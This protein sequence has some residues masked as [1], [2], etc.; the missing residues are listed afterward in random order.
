MDGV[1]STANRPERMVLGFKRSLSLLSRAAGSP[2]RG[3]DASW[4]FPR[5]RLT[6][7]V[8][9]S[10]LIALLLSTSAGPAWADPFDESPPEWERLLWGGEIL[11]RDKPDPSTTLTGSDNSRTGS[12]TLSPARNQESQASASHEDAVMRAKNRATAWEKLCGP[13]AP[14][15]V[16]LS[17]SAML[18]VSLSGLPLD[19]CRSRYREITLTKIPPLYLSPPLPGEGVWHSQDMPTGPDGNPV[20]YRTSYRPSVEYP[21][22]IV[23]MLLF[24]MSRL[25]MRL[26]LGSSEPG[27]S[28]ETSMIP[29]ELRPSL[30]AITNALWK[31]KH[32]G[33]AG[34]IFQGRVV[35]ELAPGMAT[36]VVYK[37]DSVD[38][39]EWTE[40]I[41]PSLV[42]DARQLRH[43][44]VKNS[45]VVESIVRAGQLADAEIGL[46]F[47][48]SEDPGET[49]PTYWYGLTPWQSR[50]N[51]GPDWFIASRSAFGIRPDG[52]LVFA[53]GHHIS[54]RDLAKAMVLAGCERAIHADANPHNVVGNL[55]FAAADGSILKKEKLS[56]EQKS[57]TLDR[58]VDKSYTSD[59]FGFFM[60]NGERNSL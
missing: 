16:P 51:F 28:K 19:F 36:L 4:S 43:L 20:I 39:L 52:N 44:I 18:P 57:G 17:D 47:L 23:H 53:V 15:A 32:A 48:L 11:P 34:T 5:V 27:G 56:P 46:G 40:G 37:D 30:M 13:L 35:K 3:G 45:K 24:D 41:P 38:I 14:N 29:A 7:L 10:F 26:Y 55:Y 31:Q 22:A 6:C 49:P 9:G 8:F 2:A 50:T 1:L 42:R 12:P 54:T 25:S 58:Y 60:R 21:N 33:D 59:F